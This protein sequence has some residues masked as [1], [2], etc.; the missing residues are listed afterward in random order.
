M[1]DNPR[2]FGIKKSNRDFAD[3]GSW[4][5]NQFNSS[6]PASLCCYLES[7][8]L[9]ANYLSF[10]DEHNFN[11]SEIGIDELFG[12]SSLDEDTYFA[13][14][15]A[16]SPYQ[17]HVVGTLPR[18]DL[19]IQKASDGSCLRGLEVKLTAL[20]DNV[21]CDMNDHEYGS[22]LVVRPDTI[23]YLA[24]SVIESIT[25]DELIEII[26]PD[27]INIGDWAD[28]ANVLQNIS[29][30]ISSLQ[31][32]SVKITSHQIPFLLQ[33]IWKTDGKKSTLTDNC[34]DVFVWS[35][36]AFAWFVTKISSDNAD[37]SRI[38]RQT[39]TSVWIYKMLHDFCINDRFDHAN[40]IDELSYNT[41]ND[42]AF[43]SSGN[44]TNEYMKCNNLSEPRIKKDEIKN[45]ILGGGQNLLSPERR[46]DAIIYNTPSLFR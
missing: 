43:A 16:Y 7:K 44:V 31:N 35:N 41:K 23:V 8:E 2:L 6:F 39:R 9:K 30:I 42:K 20:P 25:K 38:T 3:E 4:G 14:E 27:D 33:P 15:A 22:E 45:I 17:T 11:I 36:A 10:N 34:L 13:F 19:V 1:P 32:I 26:K 12:I 24:C 5:K 46:F 37:A 40:I 18:I 29:H 21:T 28:P